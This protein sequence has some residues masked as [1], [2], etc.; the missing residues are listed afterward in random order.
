MEP[1]HLG[2]KCN[3][4]VEFSIQISDSDICGRMNQ[5]ILHSQFVKE[6]PVMRRSN[7]FF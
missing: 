5:P 7:S 2:K 4:R 1:S 3:K 6:I